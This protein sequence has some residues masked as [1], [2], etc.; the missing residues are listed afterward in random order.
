M[1]VVIVAMIMA[2]AFAMMHMP[3]T[4]FLFSSRA[5]RQNFH[6]KVQDFACQ[7]VICID[8]H[9]I[10]LNFLDGKHADTPSH[11]PL[12]TGPLD[13]VQLGRKLISIHLPNQ[14]RC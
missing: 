7:F 4:Q 14:L 11:F 5:N 3:M 6:V 13:K 2:T 10:T 8:R 9:R 1:M 12:K